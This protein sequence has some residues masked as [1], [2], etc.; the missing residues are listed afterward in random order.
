MTATGAG[1]AEG[2]LVAVTT[3]TAAAVVSG[4]GIVV[5]GAAVYLHHSTPRDDLARREIS[6]KEMTA[7]VAQL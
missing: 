7:E 2:G 5:G 1:V 4:I 3:T 6:I